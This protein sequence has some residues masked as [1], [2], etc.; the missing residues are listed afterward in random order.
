MKLRIFLVL[1]SHVSHSKAAHDKRLHVALVTHLK[2][3]NTG[4][5]GHFPNVSCV[6]VYKCFVLSKVTQTVMSTPGE[7]AFLSGWMVTLVAP[8]LLNQWA[9]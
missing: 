7:F 4:V 6:D 2:C 8:C 9:S 1:R 3:S 5:K